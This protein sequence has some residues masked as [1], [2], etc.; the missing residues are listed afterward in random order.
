[1]LKAI[2]CYCISDVLVPA[3]VIIREAVEACLALCAECFIGC[4]ESLVEYFN[5]YVVRSVHYEHETH[6]VSVLATHILR[7]VSVSG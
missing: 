6:L 4:I 3:Y 7:S 2:V 1:M 5:R